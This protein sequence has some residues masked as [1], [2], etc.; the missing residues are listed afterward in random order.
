M[1][2]SFDRQPFVAIDTETTGGS[3]R[4]GHRIIEIAAMRF[5][6]TGARESW[7]RML[8]PH[9]PISPGAARVHG[10]SSDDLQSAP[11]FHEVAQEFLEFVGRDPVVM[12][13]APFDARFFAVH[14]A[15]TDLM[16][17]PRIYDTLRLLRRH[18]ALPS[19][20]LGP[21]VRALGL[22]AT[23]TH[24]ALADAAAT[25]ALFRRI[26][27]DGR[28]RS[29]EGLVALHGP[30]RALPD[31]ERPVVPPPLR[32]LVQSGCEAELRYG[33]GGRRLVGAVEGVAAGEKW[34]YCTLRLRGSRRLHLRVDRI[35]EARP[36]S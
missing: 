29:E 9:R 5:T 36:L 10:L 24:R 8:W 12:H 34:S 30:P 1:S 35:R 17:Q 23:P 19:N 2:E 27:Q 32:D 6:P 4:H 3:T 31:V 14:L 7:S 18:Y 33:A 11:C 20:S 22:A 16:W 25:A 13:N 28:V 15:E 26:L 21:A